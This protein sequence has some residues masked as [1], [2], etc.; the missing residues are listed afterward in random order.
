MSDIFLNLKEERANAI[1]SYYNN[2][3]TYLSELELDGEPGNFGPEDAAGR[4]EAFN[5][6]IELYHLELQDSIGYL[7][8]SNGYA[9]T[10]PGTP[11]SG[12]W[13][14]NAKPTNSNAAWFFTDTNATT[15]Y[16]SINNKLEPYRR[17]PYLHWNQYGSI[18]GSFDNLG[19]KNLDDRSSYTDSENPFATDSNFRMAEPL[20]YYG[21]SDNL[22]WGKI[23]Y[24][25]EWAYR[26]RYIGNTSYSTRT[27]T[28][29][30]DYETPTRSLTNLVDSNVDPSV[31]SIVRDTRWGN[32]N[33]DFP[34]LLVTHTIENH[35]GNTTGTFDIPLTESPSLGNLFHNTYNDDTNKIYT[36]EITGSSDVGSIRRYSYI[37]GTPGITPGDLNSSSMRFQSDYA[38]TDHIDTSSGSFRIS[39]DPSLPT[40]WYLIC[41]TN[42]SYG[43]VLEITEINTIITDPGPPEVSYKEYVY[44]NALWPTPNSAELNA[45]HVLFIQLPSIPEGIKTG[46]YTDGRAHVWE[47]IY[48]NYSSSFTDAIEG[49]TSQ[50]QSV[51]NRLD[52]IVDY[53]YSIISTEGVAGDEIYLAE[54]QDYQTAL[55]DWLTEWIALYGGSPASYSTYDAKWS[56]NQLDALINDGLGGIKQ[57]VDF[58]S[59]YTGPRTGILQDR[60]SEIYDDIVGEYT[61]GT[62]EKWNPAQNEANENNTGEFNS[63]TLNWYRFEICASPRL[64]RENG[65]LTTALNAWRTYQAKINEVSNLENEIDDFSAEPPLNREYDIIPTDVVVST[66]EEDVINIEWEA[67]KAASSYDIEFK[68]GLAGS[69]ETLVSEFGYVDPGPHGPPGSENIPD[70]EQDPPTSYSQEAYT[71]GQQA[72]VA[73]T[74]IT[75]VDAATDL[76]DDFTIYDFGLEIDGDSEI[77]VQI[78]GLDALTWDALKTAINNYFEENNISAT[79]QIV[80]SDPI[81]INILSNSN[82]NG[83]TLIINP[84]PTN[85]I[86]AAMSASLSSETTGSTFFSP[87]KTYYFRIKTN[88]GYDT[89]LGDVGDINDKDWDSQSFWSYFHPNVINDIT[90][91]GHVGYITW[92]PPDDLLVGGIEDNGVTKSDQH[93]RLEWKED[94]AAAEYNIYRAT[95]VNGGYSLIGTTTNN[96]YE[97]TSAIPGFVYYYSIQSKAGSDYVD[98]DENGIL[99]S[100]PITSSRTEGIQGKRLWQTITLEATT[101]DKKEITLTWT[102]LSGATG[103]IVYKSNVETGPFR[104][105]TEDDAT[106]RIITDTTYIDDEPAKQFVD[107]NYSSSTDGISDSDYIANHRYY[108]IVVATSPS[109]APTVK[110]YF[111]TSPASGLWTIQDIVD[112][113]SQKILDLDVVICEIVPMENLEDNTV[114]KI[115][116]STRNESEQAR[117]EIIDG[118]FGD[119]L[120]P[121]LGEM[122]SAQ[123]GG[124]AYP[125][126]NSYYRVQAVEIISGNQVRTSEF[127]NIATGTR[128]II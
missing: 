76:V 128:P 119:S 98:Y 79:T 26:N 42:S 11:D 20:E 107:T 24:D 125:G 89:T 27:N 117:I 127:S 61:L 111:I 99:L 68:E 100:N 40:G 80:E 85:D 14:E 72:I 84:G 82:G 6:L 113:I 31:W 15:H 121:L 34:L 39:G 23:V 63:T 36:F 92:D 75:D 29:F 44:E 87:G 103:Y 4:F 106:D 108:F 69:W 96:F 45:E 116:F 90:L 46:D 12:F 5:E 118:T 83:S 18:I 124:G 105:I 104:P 53:D 48:S 110:Q 73:P 32:G 17:H 62:D 71:I 91:H 93:A 51:N 1:F 10:G 13:W 8:S 81:Q 74:G 38:I 97:D 56:N 86:I 3:T 2:Y 49:I 9:E 78:K 58:N 25:G 41:T 21:N 120:L 57:L 54:T 50:V 66:D 37:N 43:F 28:G 95:S 102:P 67:A 59:N 19:W 115:R 109:G 33:N 126:V 101:K 30:Y 65:F 64:N 77:I 7:Y 94:S 16:Y 47:S 88:N 70:F 52:S 55:N 123:S 60:V 112:S 122:Q 114:Y 22:L 35:S